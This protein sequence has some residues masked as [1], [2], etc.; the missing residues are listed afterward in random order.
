MKQPPLLW[1]SSLL[2]HLWLLPGLSTGIS[3]HLILTRLSVPNSSELD[4]LSPL[5][6]SWIPSL[7]V[8]TRRIDTIPLPNTCELQPTWEDIYGNKFLNHFL[9][10]GAR[11]S[12][13]LHILINNFTPNSLSS[14]NTKTHTSSTIYYWFRSCA[15]WYQWPLWWCCHRLMK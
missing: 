6:W 8:C 14:N 13:F 7:S 2:G 3:G 5:G 11:F 15:S 1:I 12:N 4:C 10:L 9:Y